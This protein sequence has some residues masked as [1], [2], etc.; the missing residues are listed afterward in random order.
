MFALMGEYKN[1]CLKESQGPETQK[2]ALI[3]TRDN[4]CMLYPPSNTL[5]SCLLLNKGKNAK[6]MRTNRKVWAVH[7]T[8][9]YCILL[10]A[11]PVS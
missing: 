6:K 5:F 1:K 3:P 11:T 8:E 10:A 9:C 4:N 7:F 2:D